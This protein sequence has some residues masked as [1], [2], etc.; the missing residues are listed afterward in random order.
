MLHFIDKL[1]TDI[2]LSIYMNNVN[3]REKFIKIFANSK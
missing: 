1:I 2:Q 3:C